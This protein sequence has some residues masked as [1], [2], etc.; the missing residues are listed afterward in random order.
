MVIR[1]QSDVAVHAP[2]VAVDM[3]CAPLSPIALEILRDWEKFLGLPHHVSQD[4]NR[5]D[6]GDEIGCESVFQTSHK[7]QPLPAFQSQVP[8]I[9]KQSYLAKHH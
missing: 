2:Q 3:Q 4:R 1:H 7:N 6:S 9:S 5:V 8:Q